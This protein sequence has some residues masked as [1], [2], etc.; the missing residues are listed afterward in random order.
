MKETTDFINAGT[1]EVLLSID[2]FLDT[3]ESHY[4]REMAVC[5]LDNNI[6][7]YEYP[8][9]V[10]VSTRDYES[11]ST[12]QIRTTLRNLLCGYDDDENSEDN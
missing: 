6:N 1:G 3:L 8:F 12:L 11:G 2:T 10:V 5:L 9:I 4:D 7:F